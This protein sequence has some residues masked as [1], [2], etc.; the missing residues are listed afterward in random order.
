LAKLSDEE[1]KAILVE[2]Y[3]I[4]TEI[5]HVKTTEELEIERAEEE[6]RRYYERLKE[7][8]R[9][10]EEAAERYRINQKL[11]AHGYRWMKLDGSFFDAHYDAREAER[12]YQK[13][14]P[15]LYPGDWVLLTPEE[16]PIKIEEALRRI[17]SR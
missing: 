14:R 15:Y 10:D 13:C 9:R 17:E 11:K 5:G 1:L 4:K 2:K 3:N 8:K 6:K 7:K 16:E 12:F